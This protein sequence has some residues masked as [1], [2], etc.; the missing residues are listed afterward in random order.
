MNLYG[1]SVDGN[2]KKISRVTVSLSSLDLDFVTE[3]AYKYR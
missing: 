2:G 3:I 1:E